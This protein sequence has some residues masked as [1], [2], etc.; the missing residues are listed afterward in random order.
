MNI[1]YPA[2]FNPAAAKSSMSATMRLEDEKSLEQQYTLRKIS[3]YLQ[4]QRIDS[5]TF[6]AQLDA[7][8]DGSVSRE[9][10]VEGV[11]KFEV[12]TLVKTDL[13]AVFDLIDQNE[14]GGLILG[15]IWLYIEGAEQ[16]RHDDFDNKL[17]EAL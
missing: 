17:Q 15:E 7:N 4:Q 2:Y 1:Y 14:D 3:E 5:E 13:E 10:F 16:A 8:Q 6:F 12:P 9:E 11:S